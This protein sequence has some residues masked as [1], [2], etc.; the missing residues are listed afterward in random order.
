MRIFTTLCVVLLACGAVFAQAE[1]AG[2]T[3]CTCKLR[4]LRH[5]HYGGPLSG[6]LPVRLRRLAH[7]APVPADKARFGRFDELREYN[8]YV[9]NG[10]LVDAS[11]PGQHSATAKKVGDF[12]AACMDER[13][14]EAKG[15][16]PISK[17]LKKVDAIRTR[18]MW[19][20]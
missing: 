15:M 19:L 10:I 7:L 17:W 9:L 2:H 4:P 5:G 11:K 18:P 6:L 3:T 13:A 8:L 12:Y 20:P 16:Q 14:I 1:R